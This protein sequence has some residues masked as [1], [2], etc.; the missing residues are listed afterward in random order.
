MLI[1]PP[2]ARTA[3]GRTFM[4]RF[5]V[6]GRALATQFRRLFAVVGS[7][8]KLIIAG[9]GLLIFVPVEST[10]GTITINN[11]AETTFLFN[12]SV[13]GSVTQVPLLLVPHFLVDIPGTPWDSSSRILEFS[14]LTA[15]SLSVRWTFQH[16]LGPDATDVNPNPVEPVTLNQLFLRL[17]R[18]L[19]PVGQH[20]VVDHPLT[21][22]ANHFDVLDLDISGNVVSG[23]FGH[24]EIASYSVSYFC[25][26]LRSNRSHYPGLCAFA[27]PPPGGGGFGE[28]PEPSILALIGLGML[29]LFRFAPHR[30]RVARTARRGAGV[31]RMR[32]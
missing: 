21:T 8:K 7:M 22:G 15:D 16:L 5:A 6:Q 17:R 29:L 28:A 20:V 11:I 10:A 24:L 2:A 31:T 1:F 19:F 14:G 13:S 23:L 32:L 9:L 26:A 25:P 30:R 27:F 12:T 3:R 4:S 18:G